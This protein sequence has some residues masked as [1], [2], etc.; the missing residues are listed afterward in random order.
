MN[1]ILTSTKFV[2]DNSKHVKINHDK[3]DE[4]CKSFKESNPCHWI[5]DSP[6]DMSKLS[7][8]EKLNFMFILSSLNFCYWGDPKWSINYR[9]KE[10]D[11]FYGMIAALIN[12]TEN[13]I[14]LLDFNFLSNIPKEAFERTIYPNGKHTEIPLFNERLNILREIGTSLKD[15]FNC[16]LSR[17]IDES[18]KDSLKLLNL[19]ITNFPSFD[20]S[21][22]Y[23]GK[24]IYFYKR[25]QLF[26]ADIHQFFKG[27][28]YG[29][30]FNID[31][32]T[33]FADYKVP[34]ILR[35]IGILEYSKDL[36]NKIDNLMEIQK[37]TEEE[38][39]I[40]AGMIWSIE[41][42][43]E[44]LKVKIPGITS[45]EIDHYLWILSLSKN[46]DDKPYHRTRTIAY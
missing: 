24:N 34:Q 33:A 37:G 17:L 25:A 20:D 45:N 19:I 43:K 27:K 46:K 16:D 6:S 7:D 15:N 41:L 26:I 2:V 11:G 44:K 8:K 3:I 38:I 4:F 39:E 28:K 12:A 5:N 35:K 9:G 14:P 21:S 32:L 22:E 13:K 29:D 18:K 30:F 1:K 36:S 31:E 10:Y 42:I 23:K 40:R